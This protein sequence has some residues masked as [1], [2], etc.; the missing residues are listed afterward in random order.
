MAPKTST[1]PL[2]ATRPATERKR[3]RQAREGAR[4]MVAS[5]GESGRPPW[6]A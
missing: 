5:G 4:E 1:T 6:N 3:L 2:T